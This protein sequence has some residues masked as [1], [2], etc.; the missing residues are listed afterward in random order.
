MFGLLSFL[1]TRGC[2]IHATNSFGC[3]AVLWCAQGRGEINALQWLGTNECNLTLVNNNGHGVLHKAA[4]RGWKL[5]CEWFFDN[6][7]TSLSVETS[8]KLVGPDTE[9]YCPSDLA[10]MEGN[11]ELARFLANAEMKI[12]LGFESISQQNKNILPEWLTSDLGM[13]TRISE[14]DQYIWEQH[15]GIRRMRSKILIS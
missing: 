5:G 9:G 3:N 10:G 6:V 4:Q 8:I 2:N 11:E 13:S 14:K 1:F 12:A 7:M 15:G